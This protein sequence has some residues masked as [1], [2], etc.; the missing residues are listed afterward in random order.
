M[1][2]LSW[3]TYTARLPL[4]LKDDLKQH[5][6]DM[7][8][9]LEMG[10]ANGLLVGP[11][12]GPWTLSPRWEET[13]VYVVGDFVSVRNLCAFI[14]KLTKKQQGF[15]FN[16]RQTQIDIFSKVL[17]QFVEMLALACWPC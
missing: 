1:E 7:I 2:S 6:V 17:N 8:I 10:V 5:D 14:E 15:S 3:R 16:T 12:D 13:V 9:V 4:S 11:M